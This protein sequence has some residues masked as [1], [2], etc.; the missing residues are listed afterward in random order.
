MYEDCRLP[1]SACN[2]MNAKR[3]PEQARRVHTMKATRPG[4]VMDA[5]L[6]S[7]IAITCSP[8]RL[9]VS[10]TRL[11]SLIVDPEREAGQRLAHE[12]EAEDVASR[13]VTTGIE[14]MSTLSAW[15]PH[16]ILL[17]VTLPDLG[18][19]R[20]AQILRK[21]GLG[22]SRIII[23]LANS[24]LSENCETLRGNE[25]DGYTLGCPSPRKLAI[26]LKTFARE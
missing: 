11:R 8:R 9:S 25:F 10:R 23:A 15:E 18:N 19:V 14:A 16:I 17:R 7:P 1:L 13:A 2:R 24:S 26:Y 12:L 4:A 21:S 22:A 5:D 20:L 3:A 6:E